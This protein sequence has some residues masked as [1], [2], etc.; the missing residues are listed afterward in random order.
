MSRGR[1]ASHGRQIV[2]P[3]PIQTQQRVGLT[4]VLIW[5]GPPL[6]VGEIWNGQ[7]FQST[8]RTNSTRHV[9]AN[10][11]SSSH[12]S[13]GHRGWTACDCLDFANRSWKMNCSRNPS[14]TSASERHDTSAAIRP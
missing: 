3:N 9:N 11:T 4:A 12:A 5:E 1:T 8:C 13:P 10:Q 2:W 6:S 7:S 14:S